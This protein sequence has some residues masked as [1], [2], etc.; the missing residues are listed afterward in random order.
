MLTVILQSLIY[1]RAFRKET[2]ELN[3]LLTLAPELENLQRSFMDILDEYAFPIVAMRGADAAYN[4][5]KED[6]KRWMF[7]HC[8]AV[9]AEQDLK[10][11]LRLYQTIKK[12]EI[13]RYRIQQIT[14]QYK[15][16]QGG[17][18]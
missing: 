8:G 9:P 6:F 4:L 10:E 15:E 14:E 13:Q 1:G 18:P 3:A 16:E 17:K 11:W 5:L 7:E 2:T 12:G